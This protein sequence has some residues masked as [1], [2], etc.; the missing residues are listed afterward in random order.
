VWW[1]E[2]LQSACLYV[3]LCVCFIS[4]KNKRLNK[5]GQ[6]STHVAYVKYGHGSVLLWWQQNMIIL[7]Y[8]RFCGWR[9]VFAY[10]SKLARIKD[11]ACVSVGGTG[12]NVCCLW[13]H[14]VKNYGTKTV[15]RPTSLCMF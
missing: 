1:C 11:N 14:L 8:F 7:M 2:V 5:F 13:L 9:L 15:V 12:G 3:C 4:Q 6:I 10:W